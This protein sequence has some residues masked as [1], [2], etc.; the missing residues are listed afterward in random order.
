MYR[1]SDHE[2]CMKNTYMYLSSSKNGAWKN[3]QACA[4]RSWTHDLCNTSAVLYQKTNWEMATLW[5][6]N[7]PLSDTLVKYIK[8]YIHIHAFTNSFCLHRPSGGDVIS[9]QSQLSMA[10]Q[11]VSTLQQEKEQEHK[12]WQEKFN[13]TLM[14]VNRCQS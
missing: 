14:E 12:S 10:Q 13:T 2:Y 11:Q 1:V 4:H 5:V 9:L 6:Y 7:K 8:S 3:I